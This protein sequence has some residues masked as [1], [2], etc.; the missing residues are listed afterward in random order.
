MFVI[1]S[2]VS[3]KMDHLFL[4]E[5]KSICVIKR[6]GLSFKPLS[7]PEH[8]FYVQHHN[9]KLYVITQIDR[10]IFIQIFVRTTCQKP[11]FRRIP[12][13]RAVQTPGAR[14]RM[15]RRIVPQRSS[16]S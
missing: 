8:S 12:S 10:L 1:V 13:G 11:S 5:E 6:C 14:K 3:G 4:E 7:L 15:L 16:P 2:I 9:Q